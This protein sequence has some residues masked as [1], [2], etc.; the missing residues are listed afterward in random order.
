MSAKTLRMFLSESCFN[1]KRTDFFFIV[2][3]LLIVAP[4]FAA[5]ATAF[6]GQYIQPDSSNSA[7]E[8]WWAQAIGKATGDRPPPALQLL[9]Y[10]GT[11]KTSL[12]HAPFFGHRS[13]SIFPCAKRVW[14]ISM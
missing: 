5:A 10:Q 1:N 13:N 4:S 14:P 3:L 7:V 12:H 11:F 2:S 6:D 9:F 8:W